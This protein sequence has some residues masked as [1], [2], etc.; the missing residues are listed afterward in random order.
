MSIPRASFVLGLAC[1]LPFVWGAI[2]AYGL[3]VL[4]ELWVFSTVDAGRRTFAIYLL[5]GI[6]G[7]LALDWEFRRQKL[8][9][10]WWMALPDLLTVVV[11]AYLGLLVLG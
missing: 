5:A 2:V 10:E 6:A 9:P 11:A 4:P 8:A 1:L 3:S 7:F